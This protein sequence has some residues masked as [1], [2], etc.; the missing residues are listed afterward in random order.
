MSIFAFS[1]PEDEKTLFIAKPH[2]SSSSAAWLK[3]LIGVAI[4]AVI[5]SF[6]FSDWWESHWGRIFLIVVLA[7]ALIYILID[8]WNRF[9]TTYIITQCR[10][11]DITQEKF[12]RRTIT[13][14]DLD[15]T[16]EVII[17]QGWWDRLFKKGNAIIKL[18][19]NKGVLVYYDV[20]NPDVVR[21]IVEGVQKETTGIIAKEGKECD[22]ILKDDREHKVPLSYSYYGEKA[23]RNKNGSAPN[24]TGQSNGLIIVKKNAKKN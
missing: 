12:F 14:I 22:V 24:Q 8:S 15:E 20:S 3:V 19:N 6:L 13:E 23:K 21:E 5:L 4:L 17:K 2:W 7:A 9:L 11:I 16:E 18:K 10:L 1:I